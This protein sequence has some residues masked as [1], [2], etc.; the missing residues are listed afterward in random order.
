MKRAVLAAVLLLASLPALA[1]DVISVEEMTT[2]DTGF[3][4]GDGRWIIGSR[5][6]MTYLD[7]LGNYVP[8]SWTAYHFVNN[9]LGVS[10][11]TSGRRTFFDYEFYNDITFVADFSHCYRAR[12]VATAGSASQE[13]ASGRVCTPW[14]DPMEEQPGD[15]CVP[16]E[17]FACPPPGSPQYDDPNNI[18]CNGPCVTSPL[19]IGLDRGRYRLTDAAHGVRFDLNADGVAEQ[20]AWTAHGEQLAFLTLDLN[21][22]GRVD[23]GR[24]LFGDKTSLPNGATAANGF[25]ALAQH[26]SNGDGAIDASDRVWPALRLWI[27]ANHDGVSQPAELTAI[28]TSSVRS[29]GLDHHRTGGRDAYG[30]LFRFR[31]RAAFT[32]GPEQNYYDVFFVGE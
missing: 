15:N 20:T 31:G 10:Y 14:N 30:N 3:R 28:A 27:D 22:N 19:I 23:G 16:T 2:F 18:Y 25:L 4:L 26:D 6:L 11:Y 29:L 32:N 21:Q 5:V 9:T 8:T 1:G 24:E 17:W 12:A 7:S 13:V